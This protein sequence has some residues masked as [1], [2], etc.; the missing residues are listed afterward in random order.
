MRKTKKITVSASVVAMSVVFMALGIFSGVLDMSACALASLFIAFLYIEVGAPY[1]YIAWLATSLM[2]FV[3]FP[4]S[5]IWLEYL[6]VFGIYPV[7][8]AYIEKLPKWSWLMIKAVYGLA[9]I[10]AVIFLTQFITGTPFFEDVT[11][12]FIKVGIVAALAAA[13]IIYDIF[14]T[15]LI[16]F[17]FER[18]RHRL[19]N[20]LK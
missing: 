12:W 15:V 19:K 17:Y 9:V 13:F 18:L 3:F 7:L 11:Q 10:F 8:K 4:G 5:V 16:R 2:L 14:M 1:V 6:I 20:L